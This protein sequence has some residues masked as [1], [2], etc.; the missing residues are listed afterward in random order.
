MQGPSI[1]PPRHRPGLS[2]LARTSA[3]CLALLVHA[4]AFAQ[5]P[6]AAEPKQR[7]SAVPSWGLPDAPPQSDAAKLLREI[8]EHSQAFQNLEEMCED[9]GPRLT[10]S[11][12][13]RQAQAWAMTKLKGYGAVNVHEEPYAFGKAWTRGK[14]WARVIGANGQELHVAQAAW[15]PATGGPVKGEVALLE[16]KTLDELKSALPGLKGRIVLLTEWPKPNDDEKKDR[17]AFYEA[18]G[19]TLRKAEFKMLLEGSGKPNDLMTMDGSPVTRWQ[20]SEGPH[21]ILADEHAHL[22]KRLLTRHGKVEV[23]VSLEGTFS[24]EPVQAFNVVAELQGS[25]KP[26]EVVIVGGHQDSWDLGTGATDNG[27]GTVAAME[28]L[29][30][31]TALGLKPRRTLRVVLFSGEEEGLLGSEAYVK[32][33]AGEMESLQ[34]VL[35]DD[36]GSGRITGWPDMGQESARAALAAA[37]APANGEGLKDLGPFSMPAWTDHWPFHRAGVPSFGAL[38]EPLD[39]STATHHSQVDTLDH[40]VKADLVQGAQALAVTAW[41]LLNGERLQH[42]AP[43]K[44]AD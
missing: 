20:T 42:H 34:A 3:C 22:L 7:P 21:G 14:A 17:M 36:M 10:G 27:T 32:A 13:L 40:V 28:V 35:I 5:D 26:G 33:H 31:M 38:Q 4:G 18:V 43:L 6:Q 30:A 39:Y 1:A 37:M 12:K 9:I 2:L 8:A 41:G 44:G 16:A 24:K 15:S 19:A 23:E 25:E 11:E 29:R